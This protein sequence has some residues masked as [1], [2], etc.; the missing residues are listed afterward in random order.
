MARCPS[1][2][3]LWFAVGWLACGGHSIRSEQSFDEIQRLV[4]GKT[5]SEVEQLL[6]EPDNRETRLI[7]DEVWTWWD[8]TFLDGKQYAPEL[9]G[10]AVHLEITFRRPGGFEGGGLPKAAWRVLGPFAVNFSRQAPHR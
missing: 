10:Q 3:L 6:G 7:D 4:T 2:C 8:Y 1:I 9:R 5:E